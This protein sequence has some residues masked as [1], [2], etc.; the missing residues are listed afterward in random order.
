MLRSAKNP[1]AR[2]P[3]YSQCLY[4]YLHCQHCA[5]LKPLADYERTHS[6]VCVACNEAAAADIQR[7]W[8]GMRSAHSRPFHRL[9]TLSSYSN[10]WQIPGERQ[11]FHF[12]MYWYV[13]R[14]RVM[15]RYIELATHPDHPATRYLVARLNRTYPCSSGTDQ[16]PLAPDVELV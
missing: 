2:C 9:S 10:H 12:R 5:Y 1:P 14:R 15:D 8:R 4:G 16:T 13:A 11:N 3:P 7:W 6:R